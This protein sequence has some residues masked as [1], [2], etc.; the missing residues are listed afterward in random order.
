MG[1]FLLPLFLALMLAVVFQP[2]HRWF[3]AKCGGRGR[4][5]ALLTTTSILLLVLIPLLLL[6][7]RAGYEAR[8]LYQ[9]AVS[10]PQTAG[11]APRRET[12]KPLDE[13]LAP[14]ASKLA[15]WLTDK[16]AELGEHLKVPITGQDIEASVGKA[17]R[18]FVA[19]A[20]LRT[21]QFLGQTLLGLLVMLIA[22]YYF[23]ADG[24]AMIQAIV[25]LSPVEQG[26]TQELIDQF[27]SV[28][29]AV[30]VATL[31]TAVLEG[32]LMG[33]GFYFAGVGSILLLTA[34]S[35]LLVLVPIVGAVIVWAPVCL[36]LA[37]MDHRP[38][39]AVLL[40]VYCIAMLTIID[41]LFKPWLLHG[42]SNL[43][44]LLALLSVLGGVQVLGPIGILV[45]P[46]V[47]AFLQTLLNMVHTETSRSHRRAD[48]RANAAVPDVPSPSGRGPG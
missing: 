48:R 33:V 22:T 9:T 30:V 6:V 4:L 35:M 36:W 47:V 1:S 7:V 39:A 19:P 10:S 8:S 12:E 21:T 41:N 11:Q 34:L 23:F 18:Q 26:H 43:H 17:V 16:L 44:P 2:L 27:D 46:M 20:A 28:T 14:D 29:R 15:N 45:G 31:L 37:V 32:L 5:A 24:P 38:M 13:T 25:R 40:A 42:R 3:R